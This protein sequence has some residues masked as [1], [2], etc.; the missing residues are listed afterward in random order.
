M[1]GE[2]TLPFVL[3]KPGG[4]LRLGITE[5]YMGPC[6]AI[7][8]ANRLVVLLCFSSVFRAAYGTRTTLNRHQ[9]TP[10]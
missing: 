1:E 6:T 5:V 3:G 8:T 2:R 4:S 10:T 7:K 9:A